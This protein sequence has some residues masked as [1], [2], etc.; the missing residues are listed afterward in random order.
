MLKINEDMRGGLASSPRAKRLI[1]LA[2]GIAMVA[3]LVPDLS[4]RH[5]H[6]QRPTYSLRLNLLKCRMVIRGMT[7]M[8]R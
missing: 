8:C 4:R 3:I 5:R 2:I 7:G 6:Q 1:I